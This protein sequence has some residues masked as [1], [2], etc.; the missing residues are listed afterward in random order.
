MFRE[1]SH[2]NLVILENNLLNAHLR[3]CPFVFFGLKKRS[4]YLVWRMCALTVV[5]VHGH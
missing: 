4:L 1:M 3:L 5:V 2:H